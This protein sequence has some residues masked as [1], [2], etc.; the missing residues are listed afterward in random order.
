MMSFQSFS[1]KQNTKTTKQSALQNK[2][3][4]LKKDQ[5]AGVLDQNISIYA[6]NESLST[7]IER[8]CNYLHLDYSYNSDLI[9]G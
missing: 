1:Q 3:Q 9:V 5:K 6:E 8:I 7:V 2:I 4:E